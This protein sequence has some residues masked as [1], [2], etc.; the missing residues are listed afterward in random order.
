MRALVTWI[1]CSHRH[2]LQDHL[3]RTTCGSCGAV[4]ESGR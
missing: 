3:G 4:V 1:I 2:L